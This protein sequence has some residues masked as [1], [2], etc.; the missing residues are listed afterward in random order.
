MIK[1]TILDTISSGTRLEGPE[2]QAI[3]RSVGSSVLSVRSSSE[4]HQTS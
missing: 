2:P 3:P 4:C 1:T